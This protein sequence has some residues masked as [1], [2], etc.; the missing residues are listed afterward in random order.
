MLAR[1]FMP[2]DISHRPLNIQWRIQWG[3]GLGVSLL[4]AFFY[5]CL[6]MQKGFSGDYVVQD[7]ARHYLFWM[8][9]FRDASAFPNDLIADYLQAI[10]PVG[11][12][13]FYRLASYGHLSPEWLAKVLP[14]GLGMVAAGYYYGLTL[15]IFPVPLAGVMAS[16]MLSQ[17]LWCTDDLVSASPRSFIY[18]LVIPLLFYFVRRQWGLSLLFLGLLALF[19]PSVALVAATLYGVHAV[20]WQKLPGLWRCP[21]RALVMGRCWVAIAAL[22]L[23]LLCILPTYLLSHDY[24]PVVTLAQAH[25]IPELQPSGRHAFFRTGPSRYWLMLYGGHGAILKR[26]L[27]TPITLAAA[28][29]LWPMLLRRR[30][31]P[32]L[33]AVQPTVYVLAELTLAAMIWFFLAYGVAFRL[34]LPGRY[35]SHCI[36]LAVPILAAIAWVSLLDSGGLQRRRLRQWLVAGLILV[37]LLFY[38]PLLLKNFPKTLYMAGHEGP[39]YQYL[40]TQPQASLVASLDYEA[41]NLPTFA[42]R[43]VLMAPE[44]GTPFHLGY[45][46][47][48]RQRATDLL[49]A[50]YAADKA[51]VKTFADTYG[52]DFWLVHRAAFTPDYLANHRYW[53]NNYSSPLL[54]PAID[55]MEQ[56]TVGVLQTNLDRC[57]VVETANFWLV[58]M[59]CVLGD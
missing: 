25:T 27:F 16:V 14:T 42:K 2:Q 35:T 23:T 17:H 45:Y 48:M 11:Y 5:G 43:S 47:Q 10:A 13:F 21:W 39:I 7:D 50:H 9:R 52:V 6:A 28:L 3:I 18:P 19:Y 30:R 34:H 15:A 29:F 12:K 24:G 33:N 8:E 40:Q 46:R 41:D 31:F 55:Q 57:A 36:Q 53:S 56:G 44:Y 20:D 51:T 59:D 37:P 49:A 22:T 26:T 58:P 4:F 32:S 38:Y 54:Q 1:L